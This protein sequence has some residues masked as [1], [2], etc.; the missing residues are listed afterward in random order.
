MLV[1]Y[2]GALP[3]TE[4]GADELCDVFVTIFRADHRR[5]NFLSLLVL[6]GDWEWLF[7]FFLLYDN[8][9]LGLN[10]L[11]VGAVAGQ[12]VA[13]ASRVYPLWLGSCVA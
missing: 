2:L 4:R 8:K 12:V 9:F 6:H 1:F 11:P 13:G 5:W 7:Y 10:L 3:V